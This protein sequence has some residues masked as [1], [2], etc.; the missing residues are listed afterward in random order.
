MNRIDKIAAMDVFLVVIA[1]VALAGT[2][3]PL[4]GPDR[5]ARPWIEQVGA[6]EADWCGPSLR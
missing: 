3:P 2:F 1:K 5:E 4:T 6:P